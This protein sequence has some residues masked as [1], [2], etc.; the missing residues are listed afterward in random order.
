MPDKKVY[1]QECIYYDHYSVVTESDKCNHPEN[2][3]D[4]HVGPRAG[5]IK[6]P[7][8]LNKKNDCKWHTQDKKEGNK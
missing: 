7:C 5:R 8:E 2:I 6:K 4:T 1:C 3:T